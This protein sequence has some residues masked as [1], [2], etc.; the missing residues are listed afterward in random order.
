MFMHI[1]IY[2]FKSP[3]ARVRSQAPLVLYACEFEAPMRFFCSR[4]SRRRV[5]EHLHSLT[6]RRCEELSVVQ[7]M[8]QRIVRGDLH[9]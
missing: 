1:Y 8:R 3:Y 9:S 2:I 4:D 5:L 6:Q 7:A